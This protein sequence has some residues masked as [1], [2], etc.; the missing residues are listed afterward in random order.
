MKKKRRRR[1]PAPRNPEARA[2]A[3]RKFAAK[4]VASG[5]TYKRRPKHAPAAEDEGAG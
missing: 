5:K 2:L 3:D 4:T 1:P